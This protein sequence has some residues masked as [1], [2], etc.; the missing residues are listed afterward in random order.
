[1]NILETK[2]TVPPTSSTVISR[3]RLIERFDESLHR[4]LTIV[5]APAGSGKTT[6]ISEWISTRRRK[7]RSAW[8]SLGREENDPFRFWQYVVAAIS[9]MS[10]KKHPAWTVD[11]SAPQTDDL[12]H[13]I[14]WINA[15]VEYDFT[16]VLDDYHVIQAEEIHTALTYLLDYQPRLMHIAI[17]SR[18][19]PPLPLAQLRVRGQCLEFSREDLKFSNLEAGAYF[20]RVAAKALRPEEVEKLNARA[21]GWAAGLQIAALSLRN[22]NVESLREFREDFS[23]ANYFLGEYF[24]EQ[25][26]QQLDLKVV[27]SM[28]RLAQL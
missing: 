15:N 18:S 25:V 6:L 7:N 3:Q 1:M 19:V 9:P 17:A 21:E 28:F 5:S 12:D 27:D 4:K 26:L 2:I 8:I 14:N 16:L 20:N 22:A 24:Y 13:L 23:G 11:F 10:K